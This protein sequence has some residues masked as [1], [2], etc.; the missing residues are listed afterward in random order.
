MDVA[1]MEARHT[2]IEEQIAKMS[3][4]INTKV[5]D[6]PV[7]REMQEIVDMYSERCSK[8][9]KLVSERGRVSS[10]ELESEMSRLVQAKKELAKRRGE[11]SRVGGGDQLARLNRELAGTVIDLAEKRAELGVVDK[12][13]KQ[14][15][16]QLTM[17]TTFDPQ[18]SQI[19]IAR[20]T[21]ENANRRVNEL[22]NLLAGLREP[23]VTVLGVD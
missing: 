13:L 20:Q 16:G 23:T 5:E 15:E 11:L 14:I 2:A 9:E 19:R 10:P 22:E 21:L 7:A 3:N 12:Q 6:D 17:A 18:V 8:F 4:E 1:R